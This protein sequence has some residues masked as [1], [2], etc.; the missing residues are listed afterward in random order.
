MIWKIQLS[1]L[2][3]A[4]F[5][6]KCPRFN[7]VIWKFVL[8]LSW[9]DIF[10]KIRLFWWCHF[11]IWTYPVI[12][13]WSVHKN[14]G[15]FYA[16]T[17]KYHL[18]PY[19]ELKFLKK[20]PRFNGV[21]WKFELLL[22]FQEVTFSQKRRHFCWCNLKIRPAP[23]IRSKDSWNNKAVF[24][25]QFELLSITSQFW[26]YHLKFNLPLLSQAEIFAKIPHIQ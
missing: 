3:R 20:C 15:P 25:K 13:R 12:A 2:S 21:P 14:K 23:I 9:A 5:L 26:W 17:L 24:L 1:L 6:Q 10:T 16:F 19:C 7:E 4:K 8:L 18:P 22:F 11:K